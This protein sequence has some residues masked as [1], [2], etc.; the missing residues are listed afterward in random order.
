MTSKERVICSLNHKSPDKTPAHLSGFDDVE[1]WTDYFKVKDEWELR[2]LLEM[3]IRKPRHSGLYLIEDTESIWGTKGNMDA[4]YSESRGGHPFSTVES[5]K[6]VEAYNWPNPDII[7][8]QEIKKR[9]NSYDDCYA[10]GITIGWM[11]VFCILMDLFG[12]EEAMMRMHYTPGIIQA[13]ID[14]IEFFIITSMKRILDICSGDV[15]YFWCGDDFATQ[16]GMMISPEQWHKFLKP[17]YRRM[18]DLIKSYKLKVWFHSCGTFRPVLA[19]LVEMGMDIWETVQV[20]LEGNDPGELKKEYGKHITF[21]GGISTQKTLPFGTPDD[22]RKEVR[23]RIKVLGKN[24][25]YICGPDHTVQKNI[26]AENIEALFK[27]AKK[28][29]GF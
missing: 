27:E 11:G 28:C 7:N 29:A 6:E 19:D 21:F 8:Y 15:M 13:C 24:G 23:E 10:K 14:K 16:R 26:P 2:D 20:H 4:G 17:V 1:Y 22:V 12:M 9:V 25:G 18:F 3:D 5:I